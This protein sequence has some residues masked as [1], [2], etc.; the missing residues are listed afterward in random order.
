MATSELPKVNAGKR[1][2]PRTKQ[3]EAVMFLVWRLVQHALILEGARSVTSACR[4][5]ID[6]HGR[7]RVKG[8]GQK[9]VVIDNIGTL[10]DRYIDAEAA[11]HDAATYPHLDRL[12]IN[13]LDSLKRLRE[14]R[15]AR[16]LDPA[17]IRSR[18]HGFRLDLSD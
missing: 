18:A 3:R 7:I 12:C 11:R 2:R 13:A 8:L 14:G 17:R 5:I 10:R 1:G 16:R 9:D 15:D 6:R 4:M